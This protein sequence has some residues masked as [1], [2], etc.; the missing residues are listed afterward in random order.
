M[1]YRLRL[2]FLLLL[3]LV[4]A[5]AVAISSYRS[6]SEVDEATR[7]M[8]DERVKS[9]KLISNIESILPH[10]TVCY[11]QFYATAFEPGARLDCN[12]LEQDLALNLKRLKQLLPNDARIDAIEMYFSQV[13]DYGVD[14]SEALT[15]PFDWDRSRDILGMVAALDRSEISPRLK[16]LAADISTAAETSGMATREQVQSASRQVSL[17]AAAVILIGALVGVY[18]ERFIRESAERK[19]LAEFPERNPDPVLTIDRSGVVLYQN[20]AFNALQSAMPDVDLLPSNIQAYCNGNVGAQ[21]VEYTVN[22]RTLLATINPIMELDIAHVH[23]RDISERKQAEEKLIYI[24]EHDDLTG[25]RNRR[26][27]LQDFQALKTQFPDGVTGLILFQPDRFQLITA[28]SGPQVGD[29][30]FLAVTQRL[31]EALLRQTSQLV[32]YRMDGNQIGLLGAFADDMSMHDYVQNMLSNLR[33]AFEEP[34]T[35]NN[36]D[37]YV[38]FS[39]GH[40]WT[41]T[42]T[43]EADH[44]LRNADAALRQASE[45]TGGKDLLFVESMGRDISE[46]VLL[47]AALRAALNNNELFMVYQPQCD[48]VNRKLTGFESLMR[49]SSPMLGEVSPARF[50]PIAEATGIIVRMGRWALQQSCQQAKQWFEAGHCDF[51]VGVNVST[52]QLAEPDFT[53]DVARVLGETGVD[54]ALIKLEITESAIMQN[55]SEGIATLQALRDL[56]LTLALDDFGTGH[57][58]LTYLQQLPVQR[59]KIDQSFVRALPGSEPDVALV[60]TIIELG[61]RLGLRLIAEGVETEQQMDLLRSLGCEEIQGYLYARPVPAEAAAAYF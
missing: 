9:L 44:L 57:A 34:L 40:A 49:W 53:A 23:I 58:S 17:F 47:E 30:V 32:P 48:A 12:Q 1:T 61:Q 20:P 28:S 35:V 16:T 14:L 52:R 22:H 7:Q 60:R 45:L 31:R 5:A 10:F 27:L 11:Y 4:A 2:W 25:L 54:P 18:V 41:M 51:Q 43:A 3:T 56:G 37:F 36:A 33:T 15:R 39:T 6:A 46:T 24:A 21:D 50:I 26:R 13:A 42:L 19:R 59:L 55:V 29:Q 8:L 38:S